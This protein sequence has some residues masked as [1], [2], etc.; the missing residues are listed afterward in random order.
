MTR[1]RGR[2]TAVW[3]ASTQGAENRNVKPGH[4]RVRRG[5]G[6][7]AVAAL[8]MAALT[9]S[10]APGVEPPQATADDEA[11]AGASTADGTPGDGSYHT[12]LPPLDSPTPPGSSPTPQHARE[13]EGAAGIPAT[14][15]AAYR[16]AERSLAESDPGCRLPW[17]LLAAIGKVESGQARGGAVDENGT[18]LKPILG[19]VLNGAGFANITDT[20]DGVFDGDT[21]HDRAVGPMQFIPS[22]WDNWGADGNGDGR[23]DPNN[24][25]DAALAAGH[26][27][28]AGERDLTV[29]DDLDAAILSYN[30][31]NDYLRTVLSWLEFYREGVHEVPDGDGILPTSP[32]AGGADEPGDA[33]SSRHGGS[34]RNSD[35]EPG[36]DSGDRSGD[37]GSDAG[38]HQSPDPGSS[39]PG[40]NDEGGTD[41][42]EP[43][44]TGTPEPG[45]TT[46]SPPPGESEP[47]PA[48]PKALER[49]SKADVT[50]VRGHDFAEPVKVRVVGSDDKPLSGAKVTFT[51]GGS[52][53]STF[54]GD[55]TTVTATTNDDGV[56]ASPAL[57]A[58]ETAGD[59]TVSAVVAGHEALATQIQAH[60]TEPTAGK[61]VRTHTDVAY[62]AETGQEF[63]QQVQVRTTGADG[64]TAV[65]GVKITATMLTKECKK[66]DENGPSFVDADGKLVHTVTLRTGKDGL[67]TLP[68]M[69]AGAG[70]DTYTLRLTTAGLDPVDIKLT[71][72]EP[73]PEGS[74]TATPTP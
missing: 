33:G 73:A 45:Q 38:A 37:S 64:S 30:H 5:M 24:V 72:T 67:L 36:T 2:H 39:S 54:A 23:R 51:I 66:V 13:G 9:A 4:P 3:L 19:P 56:A 71:V 26:Y 63:A 68:K 10:Q 11:R 50:A 46:T 1:Y 48:T 44:A 27:L 18:T 35:R 62:E 57:H 52:T 41:G 60:V 59:F 69:T 70:A 40:P 21:V 43:P 65:A 14:V 74:T 15:L 25:F 42:T 53:G 61:L 22:T 29:K 17:E 34:H 8:A 20:D 7:T 32:G 31:S 58:G 55:K 6:A 49:I 16:K 12:E 47:T 28:C